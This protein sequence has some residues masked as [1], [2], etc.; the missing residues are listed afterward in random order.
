MAPPEVA[1]RAVVY[2][3][4]DRREYFE[5][6]DEVLRA[7]TREAV[8][9]LV[10]PGRLD[11][12]D[13][14]DLRIVNTTLG[15]DEDLCPG[16]PYAEQV[17]GANCSGTLVD[18]D[19]VLT[20]GH[21]VD[22]LADCQD[23][24]FVFDDYYEAPGQLAHIGPEDVFRCRR[25]AAR[26]RVGDVDY[27]L[28]QLDRPAAPPRRP[29]PV[30]QVDLPLTVGSSVAVIGFPDGIPA[31]LAADGVVIDDGAP[32]VEKF[33]ATLDTFSGNSGSGVY[34]AAGL[35]VGNLATGETDYVRNG[36]CYVVNRLPA[37]GNQGDAEG[38]VYV[39]R[40]LEGLCAGGW[41]GVLCGD[42]DGTC[43]PC[44]SAEACPDGWSCQASAADPAVTWCAAPCAVDPDCPSD[45]ACVN[46]GCA[47]RE[48]AVCIGNTVWS[49]NACGRPV[50]ELEVCSGATP[51]C[52]A[53]ACG[54]ADPGNSCADPIEVPAVSAVLTGT[55]GAGLT[56][57]HRG[58]CG[59][60][61]AERVFRLTTDHP[62][63]LVATVEGFDT[64]LY[65][66]S[67][68]D[69][70]DSERVCND[71]DE[72][73]PGSR[74]SRVQVRLLSGEAYL[75]LDA[76]RARAGAYTLTLEVTDLAPPDAGV[77]PDTGV[78][79]D[80][81]V[82]PDA[83]VAEVDAGAAEPDA[84]V[85]PAPADAGGAPVLTADESGCDCRADRGAGG[86]SPGLAWML[87]GLLWVARRPRSDNDARAPRA[88]RSAA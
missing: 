53:G 84:G 12:S 41:R 30:R 45:H 76:F 24:R 1:T 10:R 27:A 11:T 64:V 75:F 5:H 28:I 40:A 14:N 60:G 48:A 68:C 21:C 13:P 46:S 15:Q 22:D 66:R 18:W 63:D 54:A 44:A 26:R 8:V 23:Y 32:A 71:D 74:G 36:G 52:S 6:P 50:A 87:L 43:A 19:L 59:G 65:V 78:P 56:N 17:V 58:S 72:T 39:G 67:V 70:P 7:R 69:D 85:V 83:G 35:L 4:D 82:E 31:K 73:N 38:V 81:G 55:I 37:Q 80:S 9:A 20:A 29:A 79:L 16:E 51:V 57:E 49:R 47:P 61:G 3:A 34:D 25:I 86:G 77:P 88:S 2:G 62:V 42:A 33:I